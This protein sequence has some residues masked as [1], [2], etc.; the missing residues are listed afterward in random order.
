MKIIWENR[1]SNNEENDKFGRWMRI[2][3]VNGITMAMI[4]KVGIEPIK[5]LVQL[6]N[7]GDSESLLGTII[8]LTEAEAKRQAEE[9]IKKFIKRLN[10]SAD[11]AGI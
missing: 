8:A 1:Y 9:H 3:R 10:R 6:P 2:A 11:S 4:T 7:N 5:Y